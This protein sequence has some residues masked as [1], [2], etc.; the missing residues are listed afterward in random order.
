MKNFLIVFLIVF[1]A[2]CKGKEIN[3]V[4]V[5]HIKASVR[6]DRFDIDFYTSNK[7]TLAD[8][9]LKY[10]MLFPN[11]PDSIWIGKINDKDEREL[12]AETQ[13]QFQS[14]ANLEVQLEE[15]F[16]YVK[17]YN[18]KF[19]VPRVI[20]M[21]TDIDYTN[22]V[23]VADGLLLISLDNYLGQEHEFYNDYPQYIKQN[24]TKEHILVDVANEIIEKQVPKNSNRKFL[25]KMIYEGK[26]MYLLDRYLPSVSDNEKFGSTKGK[27][28]WALNSEE[29]VWKYFISRD[30]LYSAD[31]DLNQRFLDIAPFSKFYLGEDTLSPGR[32]GV[33]IGWQIVRSY[34][35]NNDVSLSELMKTKEDIIFK[36]S[37]YKPKR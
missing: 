20:S 14:V 9:K 13:K 33:Y 26:K 36:K 18:P 4:D 30:L 2:A 21:L 29:E 10:P 8:T 37:K 1:L 5:S 11:E 12:F 7:K 27:Y 15:L 17:Y 34:M 16:K 32:I 24:N 31:L 23:V 35:R 25:D 6:I 22:R 19:K 28:D 3:K